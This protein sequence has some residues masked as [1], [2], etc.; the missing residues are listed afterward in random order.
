MQI[1]GLREGRQER[2]RRE[3][4]D[5]H[6]RRDEC[7]AVPRDEHR[8]AG[9]DGD[10][11]GREVRDDADRRIEDRRGDLGPLGHAGHGRVHLQR[12]DAVP[13]E[14]VERMQR[15]QCDGGGRADQKAPIFQDRTV[16][17]GIR[18]DDERNHHHDRQVLRRRE[19]RGDERPPGTFDHEQHRDR[20]QRER[21]T[22]RS[23]ALSSHQRIG[24]AKS[25]SDIAAPS[26]GRATASA[27]AS[28]PQFSQAK[29]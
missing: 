21:E 14:H 9:H 24:P 16:E 25:S 26:R 22:A 13:P 8:D 18:R 1:A 15:R 2:Q 20:E 12:R 27:I 6:I 10:R 29:A 11:E 28:S 5:E 19:A 3:E 7:L 4:R 23:A 17:D